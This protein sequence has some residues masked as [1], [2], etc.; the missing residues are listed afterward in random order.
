MIEKYFIKNDLQLK[1]WRRFKS[2]K[3][4]VFSIW[5]L[6]ISLFVTITAEFWANSKPLYLNYKGKHYFPVFREY[7]RDYIPGIKPYHPKEMGITELLTIDYRR[8]NLSDDDAIIWP[9]VSWDPFESNIEPDMYPA[10]PSNSNLMGT[11]DRGRD[12]LTRLIYGMRYSFL[13]AILVWAITFIIGTIIGGV[14]GYYGGKFDFIGQRFIEVFSSVPQFFLLL[15]V[16]SIFQPSL[17][18]LVVISSL[19]GWILI[20]Y[21]MRGEFLKN[22]K[23]E[24]V[25]A[26]RSMGASQKRIIFGHILPNSLSPI[27]TFTPFVIAGGIMG[28]A[29]LDYLG[30]GLMPPTPSWGELLNQAQKYFTIAWWLAVFPSGFLFATLVMLTL[31]GDGVRDAMDPNL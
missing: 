19:F 27:I 2:H 15:I 16:I 18:W 30:F 23:R 29:S 7:I 12:V 21:Y 11:D 6:L 28:L 1:R 13:Y 9:F 22:R 4:A 25:E 8:L 26:A 20:S 31:V 24:F 5:V 3:T 10:P 14:M 17:A